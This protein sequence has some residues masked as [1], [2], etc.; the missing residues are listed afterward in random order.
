[1]QKRIL[2]WIILISLL[3]AVLT[4]CWDRKELDTMAI[5]QAVG[6]DRTE[7]GQ[8]SLTLQL[9]LPGKIKGPAEKGGDDGGKGVWIL[10][11]TGQ[12]VFEALRDATIESDRKL[13]FAHNKLFVIG[14]EAA[15]TGVKP[16]VDFLDR[17]HDVRRLSYFFIARGKAQDIIEGEHEQEKI[18]AKAIEGLAKA[19][20]ATSKL[21]IMSLHD[22]LKTLA[23]KTSDPVA[24]GIEIVERKKE[25]KAKK[26]VRLD[27]TAI[28]NRDK[29]TGWFDGRE[30][31]GLL[32]V[33]GKVK[34]GIMVVKSPLEETKNVSLEIIR[35]SSEIKPEIINGKLV[36]NVEVK[37][38]GNI[39]EQMSELDLTEPLDVFKELE[40][41]QAAAIEEEINAALAK[42]QKEWGVDIFKFGD[43]V[44]R[45][46]PKEWKEL[47]KRW[48]DEF[49]LVEVKVKVEAQLRRV[50]MST[51]PKKVGE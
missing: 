38:E 37:E 17:D 18:P 22:F 4:G 36:I 44:H 8:I 15:R 32:W 50:G 16:L 41:R 12:T 21:P 7:D 25:G 23:S 30:T 45:E 33:L 5:I 2:A 29:L 47:K 39:G 3:P 11:S 31:R 9:L 6:I 46:F 19:S 27:G 51:K 49:P 14:E 40:K 13:Y 26:F 24:P 20:G 10:T 1:M 35:A 42:A 48:D 43:A 34:S 28:F